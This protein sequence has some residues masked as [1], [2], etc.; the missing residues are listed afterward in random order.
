MSFIPPAQTMIGQ[1]LQ[2]RRW[3]T[4]AALLTASLA[5]STVT[6]AENSW[7]G[8]R[9]FGDSHV[10]GAD[11]SLPLNWNDEQNIVWKKELAGYGQSSPVVW[12]DLAFVTSA[13]GDEKEKLTITC[14]KVESGD[15]VW[16]KEFPTSKPEKVT[17]YISRSAPTPLVD[18]QRV[19][20]FFESG[21]IIA[22]THAGELVWSRSLTKQY[23]PFKGN[24]GVGSSP[25][26]T[27]DAVIVLVD[28]SGPSY[29]VSLDKQTGE[30]KWKVD[31][32]SR[33]SWSSPIVTKGTDGDEIL[34]SSNGS[35]EAIS[36][37]TGEQIWEVHDLKGNTVASPSVSPDAVLIG[38]SQAGE[39]VLIRRG[40]KGDVTATHVTWRA[41]KDVTSSFGSPLVHDGRA[42]FVSKSNV[43]GAVD[44]AKGEK[45]WT[46]R[47]PDST[48]ASP[49]AVG[50]RIYFFCKDGTTVVIRS[51]TAFEK[52]AEN[53]L[54]VEGR[55]YGVAVAHNGFLI[56]SGNRLTF[57]RDQPMK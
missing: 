29:L 2:G 10:P 19:Y 50:D 38:S 15:I 1:C 31:R 51:T 33:V 3:I 9:G 35:A 16:Q 12:N 30:N 36:A 37:K 20:A 26:Q 28:H 56:R 23:G 8:F 41:D 40:G 13:V 57:V 55:V 47:L 49:L 53:K 18:A 6:A 21:D 17:D 48:W 52:L 42:Y 14:I 24:H 34:I 43:L 45:L 4:V 5:S 32:K 46:E 44:L 7:P 25:A 27:D 54:T 39:N 22:L 11:V